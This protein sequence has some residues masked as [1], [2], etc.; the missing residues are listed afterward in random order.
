M[1]KTIFLFTAA[2]ATLVI[3]GC[4]GP[5][6]KLGRGLANT[7]EIVRWGEMRRSMEQSSVFSLDQAGY[8]TGAIHG[9]DQTIARTGLGLFEVAT[10]P[11]PPYQISGTKNLPAYP[12]FPES[13]KP[14]RVSDANFDTDTYTGYTG[15]DVAPFIPGSRFKVFDN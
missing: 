14:G 11:L 7:C 15:G 1:R 12:I 9:F 2:V 4:T 8:A 5:E 6:Q 13:Y 3:S 10:F